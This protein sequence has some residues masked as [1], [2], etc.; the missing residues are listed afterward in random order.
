MFLLCPLS[1]NPCPFYGGNPSWPE[2]ERQRAIS[3][4]ADPACG[5]GRI[6]FSLP[7]L[8]QFGPA[9]VRDAAAARDVVD[10]LEGHGWLERMDGGAVVAGCQRKAAWRLAAP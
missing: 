9:A 2:T 7:D 4:H 10:I 5:Q 1:V 3:A 6:V 8:Y